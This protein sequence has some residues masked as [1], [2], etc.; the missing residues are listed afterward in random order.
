MR[1]PRACR[2]RPYA[3]AELGPLLA[4]PERQSDVPSVDLY[5][6]PQDP[7][8]TGLRFET[9]ERGGE[10][11]DNMP[12]AITVTDAGGG[13]PC[14]LRYGSAAKSLCRSHRFIDQLLRPVGRFG[15]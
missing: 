12:Q 8:G 11:P 1:A 7:H 9:G 3:A 10:Y 15:A 14:T 13:G 6:A 4:C 2:E 5:H